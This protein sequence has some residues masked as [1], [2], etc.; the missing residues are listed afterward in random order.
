LAAAPSAALFPVSLRAPGGKRGVQQLHQTSHSIAAATPGAPFHLE[1]EKVYHMPMSRSFHSRRLRPLN[2]EN[3]DLVWAFD[4]HVKRSLSDVRSR[5]EMIN[6][7]GEGLYYTNFAVIYPTMSQDDSAVLI[8]DQALE[9]AVTPDEFRVLYL[10][11]HDRNANG[12]MDVTFL[13]TRAMV[14][15]VPKHRMAY[16]PRYFPLMEHRAAQ[17]LW[18]YKNGEWGFPGS[19][20]QWVQGLEWASLPR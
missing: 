15:D 18:L 16:T 6:Q 5:I 9:T 11:A 19:E 17:R 13:D 14:I 7:S 1:G 2:E 3:E 8:E 20:E 12:K 4:L 10:I